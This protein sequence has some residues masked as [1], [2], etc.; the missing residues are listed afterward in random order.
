MT[1]NQT[2][3]IY[4]QTELAHAISYALADLDL[5]ITLNQCEDGEADWETIAALAD[6]IYEHS[7]I[8]TDISMLED[9]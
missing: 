8:P 4:T 3:R 1:N 6:R 2:A 9:A 7:G 5:T